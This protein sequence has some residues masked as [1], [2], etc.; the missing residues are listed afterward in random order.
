MSKPRMIFLFSGI[1]VLAIVAGIYIFKK[2]V[3]GF[4]D[5]E[6]ERVDS[7][8]AREILSEKKPFVID[9]R[10]PDEFNVS[11]LEGSVRFDESVIPQLSKD[12]PILIYCTLGVRS[13]R[14]AKQ[15]SDMGYK[16][17]DMKDGILGWAN[18][19]LPLVDN[20]NAP[21]EKVHTYNQSISTLLKNGTAVY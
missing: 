13:N 18:E 6:I 15:L 8:Q 21:T 16:V 11:H 3:F 5:T 20:S 4:W 1:L 14:V 2:G 12:Q 7:A 19:Q 17:Y 10:T 9:A